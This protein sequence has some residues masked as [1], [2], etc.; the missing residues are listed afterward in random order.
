[1][2]HCIRLDSVYNRMGKNVL[3]YAR[4]CYIYCY[5]FIVE[6]HFGSYLS[7]FLHAEREC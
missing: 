7:V 6:E 5:S 4:Q 3:E 1:M 2:H